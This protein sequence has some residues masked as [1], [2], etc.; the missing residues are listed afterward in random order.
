MVTIDKLN[1]ILLSIKDVTEIKFRVDLCN[2]I[3]SKRNIVLKKSS[4]NDKLDTVKWFVEYGNDRNTDLTSVSKNGH[5]KVVK[6]LEKVISE[7]KY[8][9]KLKIDFLYDS[10][11]KG[12]IWCLLNEGDRHY[13]EPLTT[14]FESIVINLTPENKKKILVV[15]VFNIDKCRDSSDPH[16]MKKNLDT[17]IEF[18][19]TKKEAE[20][21]FKQHIRS[22]T[23]EGFLTN[24]D[25]DNGPRSYWPRWG[26]DRYCHNNDN[27][28]RYFNYMRDI[29][30]SFGVLML[31]LSTEMIP[32]LLFH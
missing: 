4:I 11:T 5:L 7:L 28:S 21:A 16:Y 9:D 15:K 29:D 23:P 8:K 31:D 22:F 26:T 2:G 30:Y 14:P 24:E 17:I 13:Y 27:F 12:D 3:N 10:F 1:E 18:F 19:D 20:N 32:K 6:Y 25:V